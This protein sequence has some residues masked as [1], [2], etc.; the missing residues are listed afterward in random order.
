[1]PETEQERQ[2]YTVTP[3]PAMRAKMGQSWTLHLEGGTPMMFGYGE[4]GQ[5]LPVKL[6]LTS[7]RAEELRRD[8]YEVEGE[9]L[10]EPA[11]EPLPDGD[12]TLPLP[13]PPAP[14]SNPDQDA[15]PIGPPKGIPGEAAIPLGMDTKRKR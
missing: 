14:P 9:K 5:P 3:G 4:D 2:T 1:M 6:L 15:D 13:E 8:G 7:G 10:P 11:V 12:E